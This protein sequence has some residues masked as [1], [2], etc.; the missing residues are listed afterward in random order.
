MG[1]P[2]VEEVRIF[3][4]EGR[5]PRSRYYPGQLGVATENTNAFEH[6]TFPRNAT[7]VRS[8]LGASNVYR[9]F[10]KNFSG[11]AKPL[12]AMLKKDARPTWDDPKPEVVEAFDTLK[13]K[14]ISPPILAL[15]KKDRPYMIDTDASAYQLGATLLQQQ[16]PSNPKE[17]VPVGYWSKTLNSAEQNHSATERECYSVVC[18]V[19]TLRPY[20]EG[21][22]S[23]VRTDHD[24]L[25]WLLTLKD[26]SARLIR[27]RLRL[28]E[29]DFEIQYRAGRV[30]QVPDTLS[31]LLTP[32]G[33][34]D[35]PVDDDV[36]TFGDHDV[37]A[38][39]RASKRSSTANDT[40]ANKGNP[41]TDEPASQ[42]AKR[43]SHHDDE[44]TDDVLDEALDVFDIGI[45]E[46]TYE[47]IDVVPADVP[48]KI[49]IGEI[50]EAQKTDSFC[51]TVLARQSKRIDS[52]FFK[53]PDGLL[54]RHHPREAGIE[55]IVLPETLRPRVL[56]LAHYAKLSGHPGQTRMYYHVRRTYYWPYMAADIFATVRNCTTCAKNRLKL[57]KRTN[58][59][60]LFPAT[61][62]LASLCIDIFGPLTKSKKG[63]VFLLVTTYRFTK[64][65]RVVA[66]AQDHCV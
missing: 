30:H 27:W 62:P 31:R 55:Q 4:T 5:L 3:R 8:F 53:G 37:L 23:V 64:L 29:F 32:V 15:P 65:T 46:Q 2:Q 61:K 1:V 40:D 24:S 13:R 11:I 38:V 66:D 54:R 16:D 43:Y 9:R 21:Q 49:T 28:S 26:P 48:A 20:I 33:S 6:A 58:P 45:A 56:Q 12:N 44:V 57:R 19:T 50:L 52:A 14:L 36:P 63:N 17:W 39:T 25:R 42:P 18:A 60:K 7:Q 41:T 51:Q 34:D 35:R 22:K 59:L 47:T 10:V